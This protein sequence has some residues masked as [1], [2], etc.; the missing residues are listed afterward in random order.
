MD[1]DIRLPTRV[2]RIIFGN[3]DI[4]LAKD[5][6]AGL[7]N[8]VDC[9][10]DNVLLHIDDIPNLIKALQKAQEVWGEK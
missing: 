8:I 5:H 7:F 3:N 1:I 9:D 10:E 2:D 4:H 6:C